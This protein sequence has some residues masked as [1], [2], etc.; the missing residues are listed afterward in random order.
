MLVILPMIMIVYMGV[1]YADTYHAGKSFSITIDGIY[2]NACNWVSAFN[3][4]SGK[5]YMKSYANLA[6]PTGMT[7]YYTVSPSGT[8]HF[9][10]QIKID[11]TLY[12]RYSTFAVSGGTTYSAYAR[13]NDLSLTVGVTGK[14][15][16]YSNNNT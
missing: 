2:S 10:S 8:T 14:I 13:K 7:E 4:P 9:T 11:G 16:F 15:Y 3:I 6:N 12:T 5:L 1:L